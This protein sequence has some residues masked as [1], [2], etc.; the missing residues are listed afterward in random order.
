MANV[1]EKRFL[2][3]SYS[4]GAVDYREVESAMNASV[5]DW[6]RYDLN[7][8]LAWTEKTPFQV[9][10]VLMTVAG[11]QGSS[12]LVIEVNPA[13]GYASLKDWAWE[14]F[15]TRATSVPSAPKVFDPFPGLGLP[16]MPPFTTKK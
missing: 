7:C 2:H 10:G 9:A 16:T 15:N 14:W 13:N 12:F 3:I 8:Y 5:E 1:P 6:M 11:M 4:T